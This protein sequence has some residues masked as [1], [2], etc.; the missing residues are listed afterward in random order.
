MN[1]VLIR[2]HSRRCQVY[3]IPMR[4]SS[5]NR[6]QHFLAMLV[7]LRSHVGGL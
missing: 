2:F 4:I 7:L 1:Y 5:P 6:L 3:N